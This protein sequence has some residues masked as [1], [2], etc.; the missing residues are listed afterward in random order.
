MLIFGLKG[1]CC[2]KDNCTT[3]NFDIVIATM[4]NVRP[5]GIQN[6]AVALCLL[7]RLCPLQCFNFD[8]LSHF[9][10][11][12]VV[13]SAPAVLLAHGEAGF[14]GGFILASG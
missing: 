7:S 12:S 10:V 14:S 13:V 5:L 4:D 9:I 6:L 1:K 8:A 11:V 2:T 3:H